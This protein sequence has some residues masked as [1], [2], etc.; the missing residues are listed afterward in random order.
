MAENEQM[1]EQ[2]DIEAKRAKAAEVAEVVAHSITGA[3]LD[4]QTLDPEKE[5]TSGVLAESAGSCHNISC[6]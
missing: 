4:L 5:A 3:V 6:F 2:D 1:P